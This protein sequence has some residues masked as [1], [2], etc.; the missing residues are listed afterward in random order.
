MF[1]DLTLAELTTL[2]TDLRSAYV[3]LVSGALVV[4]VRYGEL[5][6]KFAPTT[7]E[8]CETLIRKVGEAINKLN[9]CGS[10][11]LIVLGT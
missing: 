6:H 9:G 2:K 4:E 7:P 11:P 3:K 1:D 8:A 5:G 10:G